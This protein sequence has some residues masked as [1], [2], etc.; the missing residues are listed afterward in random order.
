MVQ[1]HLKPAYA[2]IP[3][4]STDDDVVQAGAGTRNC[5]ERHVHEPLK[6]TLAD[7]AKGRYR[8]QGSQEAIGVPE[9][10]TIGS[11]LAL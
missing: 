8:S 4:R 10:C 3:T 2:H 9:L 11:F 7:T 1:H 5:R 6:D